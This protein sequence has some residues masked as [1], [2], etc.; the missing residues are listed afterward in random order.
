[1]AY[2]TCRKC[3]FTF[4]CEES[5]DSCPDCAHPELRDAT[6][7]EIAELLEHRAEF[8]DGDELGEDA[9]SGQVH[10]VL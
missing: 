1:M 2:Y 6:G 7:E 3:L 10:T 4:E 5:A 9:G 8:G